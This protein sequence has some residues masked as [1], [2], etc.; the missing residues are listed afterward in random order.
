MVGGEGLT[1]AECVGETIQRS[2]I[3]PQ[4]IADQIRPERANQV[5]C[6]V[7]SQVR[8]IPGVSQVLAGPYALNHIG[9]SAGLQV[10]SYNARSRHARTRSFWEVAA[11][12]PY[13]LI[14]ERKQHGL[15]R[16][17]GVWL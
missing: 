6:R 14:A 9:A 7:G 17:A 8:C 5:C 2:W 3:R 10:P 11:G 4:P 13:C 12:G 16:N 15:S 1:F